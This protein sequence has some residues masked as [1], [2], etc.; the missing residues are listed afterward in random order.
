VKDSRPSLRYSEKTPTEIKE[1]ELSEVNSP[2]LV[3]LQH[4]RWHNMRSQIIAFLGAVS[5]AASVTS[6]AYYEPE[7][8]DVTMAPLLNYGVNVSTL[9]QLHELEH[10]KRSTISPCA[11]AVCHTFKASAASR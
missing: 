4:Q 8:F 11:A 7:G 6:Q 9:P 1:A 10:S 5:F 2:G 3:L